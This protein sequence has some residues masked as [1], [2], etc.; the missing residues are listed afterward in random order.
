MTVPP[1]VLN[2]LLD[3]PDVLF[4]TLDGAPDP[5][6]VRYTLDLGKMWHGLHYLLTGTALGGEPPLDQA[7][8]GGIELGEDMGYG[9]PRY[10][11]P[12]EVREVTEA[13]HRTPAE[14]FMSR[15]NPAAMNDAEIYSGALEE[16]E[17]EWLR[18]PLE[19]LIAFYNNA[20]KAQ[21]AVLTYIA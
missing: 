7:I 18:Q 21:L 6:I 16:G 2:D 9:P 19:E 20:A 5:S 4:S 3:E 10:L 8:L 12:D 15:F 11:T 14:V 1:E 17:P 13:L